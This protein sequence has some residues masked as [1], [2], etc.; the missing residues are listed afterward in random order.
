VLEGVGF[1]GSFEFFEFE[2]FLALLCHFAW[3][4]AFCVF[5]GLA[6]LPSSR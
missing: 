2:L 6:I 1:K 3:F 5:I 4:I